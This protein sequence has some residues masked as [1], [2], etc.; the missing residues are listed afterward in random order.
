MKTLIKLLLI[1]TLAV[2]VSCSKNTAPEKTLADEFAYLE[3]E[4]NI[5][6]AQIDNKMLQL[7]IKLKHEQNKIHNNMNK[8]YQSLLSE[9][10]ELEIELK[11]ASEKTG[12]KWRV[13]KRQIGSKLTELENKIEKIIKS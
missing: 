7:K 3:R 12:E 8:D 13:F 1:L 2:V 10:K 5:K 4:A 9:K 11:K 6:L